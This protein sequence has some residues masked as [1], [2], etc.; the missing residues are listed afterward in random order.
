[1]LHRLAF[2]V[3]GLDCGLSFRAFVINVEIINGI[4]SSIPAKVDRTYLVCGFF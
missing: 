2:I 3:V 4:V 1:M